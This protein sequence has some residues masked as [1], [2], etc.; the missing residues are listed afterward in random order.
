MSK[1]NSKPVRMRRSS[2]TMVMTRTTAITNT[3]HNEIYTYKLFLFYY[4]DSVNGSR[5]VSK[6]TESL[7]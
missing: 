7:L 2:S 1:I 4:T 5:F 6:L 3:E